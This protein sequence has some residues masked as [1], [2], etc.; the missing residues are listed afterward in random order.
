MKT[1]RMAGS[2]AAAAVVLLLL[3]SS[4]VVAD[5]GLLGEG[6]TQLNAGNFGAAIADFNEVLSTSP[7]NLTAHE[8]LAWAYYGSKDFTRAAEEADRR[9]A[10][11]PDDHAWRG[12]WA[13]IVR[14]APGRA[15]EALA[16]VRRWANEAP[17]DQAAQILLGRML[18]DSGDLVGARRLLN[19]VLA[20]APENVDALRTLAEI[21]R[22]DQHYPEAQTLLEKAAALQP[23]DDALQ[24][25]LAEVTRD[26]KAFHAAALQPTIP[27]TLAVILFAVIAGQAS[28]TARS[29][30]PYLLAGTSALVAAAL[31]WLYLI[32]IG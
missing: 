24:R 5:D 25:E 16:T 17:S 29:M 23:H 10:L 19:A 32:P 1:V 7:S 3:L 27:L 26:T 13:T 20:V 11:A 31:G 30:W 12:D 28:R 8:G 18:G 9:L 4:R 22:F 14:D 21:E 6:F 2:L 15:D